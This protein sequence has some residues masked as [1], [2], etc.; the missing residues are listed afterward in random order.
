MT[1]NEIKKGLAEHIKRTENIK[2]GAR[3]ITMVDVE[4]LKDALDLINRQQAEIKTLQERNVVLRGMIDTQKA[5]IER[6][7]ER[8]FE[9]AEKGEAVCIAYKTAKAEAIKEFAER[10]KRHID[11]GH[12]RSPTE[13]CF[14]ELAVV[15]MLDN[16]VKEMVGDSN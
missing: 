6:L 12:L 13:I 9:L 14:S 2:Y 11:V 8:N 1:D 7:I 10:V 16:L 15:N 5:E 4:L 3:K